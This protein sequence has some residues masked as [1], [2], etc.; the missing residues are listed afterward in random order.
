MGSDGNP[1]LGEFLRLERERRG[2]TIE[3]VA[4]ATKIN[5]RLLHS[6]EADQYQ[7]LPAKPFV[8]GFVTSYARFINLDPQEILTRFDDFIDQKAKERPAR[9]GGHS[10]YAFE[11]KEGEQSRTVLWIVMGTFVLLGGVAVLLLKPALTHTRKSH[12]EKLRSAAAHVTSA[13]TSATTSLDTASDTRTQTDTATDT[14]TTDTVAAEASPAPVTGTAVPA[15]ALSPPTQAPTSTSTAAAQ[16]EAPKPDPLN[17]GVDLAPGDIK[18]KTIFKALSDVRV[19]YRVDDKPLMKFILRKDRVLVLRAKE[20]IQF[21]V[22]NPSAITFN[23][24]NGERKP[25][26]TAKNY[27]VRNGTATLVF[28]PEK[29]G[30]VQDPFPSD[31]PLLD[32]EPKTSSGASSN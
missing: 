20:L 4:S 14:T 10:G 29:A 11:K 27:A 13:S 21:Q 3:Q 9:D 15:S 22:S 23:L 17:S 31:Q 5:V 19:R 12:A 25:V 2:I 16:T 18:Y 8:R 32:P 6:L 24:N 7:E 28:P 26:N 30:N 1:S